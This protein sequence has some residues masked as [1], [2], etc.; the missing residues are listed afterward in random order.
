MFHGAETKLQ[1][2]LNLIYLLAYQ[3]S[4]KGFA[5]FG[6]SD[7]RYHIHGGNQRLP[8]AIA[9]VL[10]PVRLRSRLTAIQARADGTVGLSFQTSKGPEEVVA[11][12]VILTLRSRGS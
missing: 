11:D 12:R 2:S 6:V 9:A 8:E 5:V 10:P 1:S 4:P 3:P 7:E